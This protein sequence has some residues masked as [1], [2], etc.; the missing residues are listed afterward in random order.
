[1]INAHYPLILIVYVDDLEEN[2]NVYRA[3]LHSL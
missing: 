3:L 2:G 1:M